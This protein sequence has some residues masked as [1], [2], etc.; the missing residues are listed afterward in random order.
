MEIYL[1]R[2]KSQL[3]PRVSGVKGVLHHPP[4]TLKKFN[5]PIGINLRVGGGGGV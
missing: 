1:G 2:K 3:V 5:F 4:G